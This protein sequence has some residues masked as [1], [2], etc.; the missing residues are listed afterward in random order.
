MVGAAVV[1]PSLSPMVIVI[2]GF[3]VVV[4]CFRGP[5]GTLGLRPIGGAKPSPVGG[6][7]RAHRPRNGPIGVDQER[8]IGRIADAAVHQRRR[9]ERIREQHRRFAIKQVAD[10]QQAHGDGFGE[11]AEPRR[12]ARGQCDGS[13]AGFY[14]RRLGRAGCPARPP[15][16]RPPDALR[17][18]A[19]GARRPRP[20]RTLAPCS[21]CCANG[22][23][24]LQKSRPR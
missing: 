3:P 23:R 4:R 2:P 24:S 6:E 16:R 12:Q 13:H 5:G 15:A 10:R 17:R 9:D 18:A 8:E 19:G 11:R 21:D 22:R 1:I 14:C 7:T 20:G